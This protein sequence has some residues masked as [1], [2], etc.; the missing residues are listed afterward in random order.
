MESLFLENM[1][2]SISDCLG[3][4]ALDYIHGKLPVDY[5]AAA[6]LA[7]WLSLSLKYVDDC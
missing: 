5:M 7:V 3:G 2:I 4:K 1:F 6:R